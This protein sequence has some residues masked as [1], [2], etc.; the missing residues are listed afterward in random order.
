MRH[1]TKTATVATTL[2]L[3]AATPSF[4]DGIIEGC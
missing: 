4:A 1:L 3:L 2:T